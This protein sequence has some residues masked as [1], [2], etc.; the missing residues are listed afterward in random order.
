MND[1]AYAS[2]IDAIK[3]DVKSLRD[4]VASLLHALGEDI[5]QRGESARAEALRRVQEA[6]ARAD[7]SFDR[8]GETIE[9]NPM[10][11]LGTAVGLGFLIGIVL[12]RR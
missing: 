2:E 1:K 11:A 5:E 12:G 6:R 7:A 9:R 8:L 4:D 10:T 3:S